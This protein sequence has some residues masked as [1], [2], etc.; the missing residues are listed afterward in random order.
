MAMSIMEPQTLDMSAILLQA[1]ELGDLIIGSQD[2]A[3]YQYWK[4]RVAEDNEAQR[5]IKAFARSKEKFEECERFGHFHPDYHRALDEV[6][7][8]QETMEQYEAIRYLKEAEQSLDNLLYEV[9]KTIAFAVSDTIKVPS[10]QLEQGGN[11]SAGGCSGGC[12]SCG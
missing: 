2:I 10:D 11:C 1:Y 5:L 4:N 6:R 9:S 12:S 8:V 7:I 3:K